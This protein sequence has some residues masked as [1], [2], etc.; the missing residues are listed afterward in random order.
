MTVVS[1][2]AAKQS[3]IGA[4]SVVRS[5]VSTADGQ[6]RYC[7]RRRLRA[8]MKCPNC[9]FQGIRAEFNAP[10]QGANWNHFRC[11][12]CGD[13]GNKDAFTPRKKEAE[14]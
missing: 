11:P 9:G 6:R 13:T 5:S 8:N 2:L 7:I 3:C 14:G 10:I 1:V 4:L 12:K